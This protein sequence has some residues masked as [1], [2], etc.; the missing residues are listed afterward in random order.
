MPYMLIVIGYNEYTDVI[1]FIFDEFK[2]IAYQY[3][4]R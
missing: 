3:A 4:N 2:Q 1:N